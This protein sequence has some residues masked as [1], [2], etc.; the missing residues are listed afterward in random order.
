MQNDFICPKCHQPG[1]PSVW[2]DTCTA[3]A[4]ERRKKSGEIKDDNAAQKSVKRTTRKSKPRPEKYNPRDVAILGGD[5][6][7]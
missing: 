3:C 6:S 7:L 4:N 2:F 5:P 1:L